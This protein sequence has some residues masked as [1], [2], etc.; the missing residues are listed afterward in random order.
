M[1]HVAYSISGPTLC[2]PHDRHCFM[3]VRILNKMSSWLTINSLPGTQMVVFHCE[4][5]QM[6][7]VDLVSCKKNI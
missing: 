3:T 7:S 1:T 2:R 6:L 4:K 5:C